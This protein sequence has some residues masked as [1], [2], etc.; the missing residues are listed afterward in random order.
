MEQEIEIRE[1]IAIVL[2]RWWIILTLFILAVATSGIVS[3]F[4]LTPVYESYTDLF[5]GRPTEGT[6][7]IMA[8]IQLN[9]SLA[10]TYADIA[11]STT[12]A[13]DSINDLNLDLTPNQLKSKISV[14]TGDTEIIRI[15][16][17]DES[18]EHAAFLANGVARIFMRNVSEIM[19]IENVSIIDPA[20]TSTS[21]IKPRPMLN[22]AIAG[23]LALMVGFFLV[24]M[25]EY[26]DNTIKTPM[27][28]ERNL[29]ITLLG[30]V[31]VHSGD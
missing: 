30:T 7:V 20:L 14:E 16:V 25:L 22:I 23:V 9:R 27:D 5:V 21:P 28:I 4:V 29:E 13:Q 10:K 12:V 2:K 15:K 8:D 31:P 11:K 6:Q 3:F 19:R 18:P 1:I 26:L 24:F 17:Q